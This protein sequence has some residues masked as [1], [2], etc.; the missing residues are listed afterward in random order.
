MRKLVEVPKSLLVSCQSCVKTQLLPDFNIEHDTDLI[1]TGLK[2]IGF[3]KPFHCMF[4]GLDPLPA[5]VNGHSLIY[6]DTTS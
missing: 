1:N 3:R 2:F 6:C 4:K 5:E